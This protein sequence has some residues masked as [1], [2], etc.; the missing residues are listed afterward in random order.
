MRMR[1]ERKRNGKWYGLL[2]LLLGAGLWM[3]NPRTVE[4]A[5]R[6][7]DVRIT[8]SAENVLDYSYEV[9]TTLRTEADESGNVIFDEATGNA[10][11]STTSAIGF[12]T[13]KDGV[14]ISRKILGCWTAEEEEI[15]PEDGEI[16]FSDLALPLGGPDNDG[17]YSLE[18]FVRIQPLLRVGYRNCI[19]GESSTP[20]D[21]GVT[22]SEEDDRIFS[23]TL[24]E[25][26]DRYG[27][28]DGQIFKGWI[29]EGALDDD[30]V[31]EAG[32]TVRIEV[33]QILEMYQYGTDDDSI[34]EVY[35]AGQ[36]TNE[37]SGPGT[38]ALDSDY[39]YTLNYAASS[40]NNDGCTYSSDITFYV[41]SDGSYTFS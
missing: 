16:T 40:V 7:I 9:N 5:E 38:Y 20:T 35:F 10:T 8:I 32:D 36:W 31:Y 33:N 26:D 15:P 24:A 18:L 29:A 28:Q 13:R 21:N 30:D 41:S 14:L 4:A 34:Y 17:I 22:Y 12:K 37:I 1:K 27:V 11:C 25:L 39:D 19:D 3:I 6:D 2:G 23:V